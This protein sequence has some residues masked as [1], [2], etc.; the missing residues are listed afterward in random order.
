MKR[1]TL[2]LVGI[3]MAL[4]AFPQMRNYK[5][6]EGDPL[7][8]RIYTL[9]NGLTVYLSQNDNEPRVQTYIVV[10]AG[11]KNDPAE[12]TGLAHY[13]EHIMFKGTD[14]MG[15]QNY[16]TEKPLLDRIRQLYE[17]YRQTTDPDQR[18]AIYHEIDSVSYE[19]S[20]LAIA[21]EY[22]KLMAAIGSNESNAWTSEDATCYKE[23]IPQNEMENWA[24][25]QS[26]RMKHMVVR[27]FHTELEAVYE[28]YNRSLTSDGSKIYEKS[29]ALLFPNHPYGQHTV[30]GTQEH[31][32][33]PSI[34]NIENYYHTYYVPNNVAICMSGDLDFD[35][36]M[37]IIEKYFG[38]WQ[39]NPNIPALTYAPEA[40]ITQPKEATVLGQ[41]EEMVLLAWRLPGASSL[42]SD[43]NTILQNLLCNQK[44]G[45]FDENLL[46]TQKLL[47]AEAEAANCTDYSLLI[48]LAIP[49]EDQTLKQAAQLMLD[50]V[51]KIGRGEWD[52]QLLQSI[53]NNEKLRFMRAA[54]RNSRR[55]DLFVS[56]FVNHTDWADAVN[57][58]NRLQ[59]IT[60][61][62]VCKFAQEWLRNNNYAIVYKE[63]GDDPNQ[64]KIDKPQISPILMNRDKTSDY[65][66]QILSNHTDP[67]QPRFVDFQKDISTATLAS[68]DTLLYKQNTTDGTFSLR[69]IYPRGQRNDNT[70]Q[71]ATQYFGYLGTNKKSATEIQKAFYNLACDVRFDVKPTQTTI[72]LTG[73]AE[74]QQQAIELLQQ[75]M[76]DVK[77]DQAIY[78][79]YVDDIMQDREISKS[80]EKECY[81]RLQQY[82]LCGPT[83]TLTD[84]PSEQ[85]L[86]STN[87]QAL[88]NKLQELQ[89]LPK[90]ILYYGPATQA[91]ISKT[92]KNS[93]TKKLKNSE[94]Q[95]TATYPI[96][97][98]PEN[99]VLLAPYPSKAIRMAQ[100]SCTG[101][102]FTPSLSPTI[103]LF[104]EYFG[105]GMNTIVFQELRESRG[106]A[107]QASA[108]Y[109]E[110]KEPGQ[111]NYFQTFIITQN[112]K[113]SDCLDVF[114]D[115]IDH[116]PQSTAAFPLAKEALIKRI[117]SQRVYGSN[118]LTYVY[119]NQQKGLTADPRQ[120]AYR[121]LQ[122][123]TLQDIADFANQNIAN[124]TYKYIILGDENE[125]DQQKL[126]SL[127]TV[128]HLTLQDIF[129]Y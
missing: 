111:P 109:R 77:A 5:T 103:Q 76:A 34:V 101:Q 30:I 38:D 16:A 85:T 24:K 61:D 86:R 19:A 126:Q 116:M 99:E 43:Y 65:V 79:N 21:N 15:T 100:L 4:T 53:V 31:L 45:L 95:A 117:A 97:T 72:H 60:K 128:R 84:I 39:P 112:D 89:A 110:P 26:D 87:P 56:A 13:L 59:A 69:Y 8:T 80:Q 118:T 94:T 54:E 27:G 51:E 82:A 10:R 66:A 12:T 28:E 3:A 125:L 17:V 1:I 90:T 63:Q 64:K 49:K 36:T 106:L 25:V 57:R 108:I 119:E 6:V 98:T 33:N 78:D 93:K 40:P 14:Q 67:I 44:A 55:A 114:R 96:L 113:M 42:E 52:E 120:E 62:D 35:A 81:N 58:I 75:W 127:G 41:E 124:H 29:M 23:D 48:A 74:N 50:E 105:G 9:S 18:K 121:Q 92:L 73:L 2:I 91:E 88:A 129:G 122:T 22:D 70:L 20:K 11:G 102:P 68:G 115:I 123:L 104:N 107:Y 37:D 46:Q 7:K 83:N 71:N 32:K 47:Y